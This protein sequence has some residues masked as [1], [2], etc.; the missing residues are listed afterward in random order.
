MNLLH[1]FFFFF[2]HCICVCVCVCVCVCFHCIVYLN[3]LWCKNLKLGL[4]VFFAAPVARQVWIRFSPAQSRRQRRETPGSSHWRSAWAKIRSWAPAS[5]PALCRPLLATSRWT[6]LC[7][8]TSP[9][10]IGFLRSVCFLC[11]C[12]CVCAYVCVCVCLCVSVCLSV[13]L[14]VCVCVC[15]PVCVWSLA[16]NN[17]RATLVE[18]LI[19][20]W[21][22]NGSHWQRTDNRQWLQPLH[23]QS[24]VI[25][26]CLCVCVCV[27]VYAHGVHVRT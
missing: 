22:I 15:V 10:V 26:G 20:R 5:V 18:C 2:F 7:S 25:Y 24:A 11:V 16:C 21:A 12:M 6:P 27:C 14:C 17:N 13:C 9:T 1:I 19:S 23:K 8:F 3:L 4:N